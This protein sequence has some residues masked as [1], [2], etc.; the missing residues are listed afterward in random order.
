[1]EKGELRSI[2]EAYS[3]IVENI[4]SCWPDTLAFFM[5]LSFLVLAPVIWLAA[6]TCLTIKEKRK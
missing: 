3:Y 1:M 2:P 6:W 4:K 5:N